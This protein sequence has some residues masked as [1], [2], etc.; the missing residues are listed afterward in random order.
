MNREEYEKMFCLEATHWWFAGMRFNYMQRVRKHFRPGDRLLDVGTGTGFISSELRRLGYKSVGVDSSMEALTRAKK[1]QG[2]P[3]VRA[4]GEFLPFCEHSFDGAVCFD[5]LEHVRDDTALLSSVRQSIA[6]HGLLII[7]VPA[8]QFI[9]GAHDRALGHERRYSRVSLER[10][11]RSSGFLPVSI[12][13]LNVTLFPL[14]AAIRFVKKLYQE[15]QQL[16]ESDMSEIPALMNGM[17]KT[18]LVFE[19]G[20][21]PAIP[22]LPGLSL[23]AVARSQ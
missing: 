9:F 19:A 8:H 17:L 10:A 21:T 2:L 20:W 11:L 4:T 6:P 18:L 13:W 3:C 16:A 12:E 15:K 22:L 14:I 1:R 7:S 23:L 5:T